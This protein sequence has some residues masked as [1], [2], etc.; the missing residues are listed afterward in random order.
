V[1][2]WELALPDQTDNS[3]KILTTD[4]T[5]ASWEAKVAEVSEAEAKAGTEAGLRQWSPVRVAQ[6]IAELAPKE[7]IREARTSNTILGVADSGK[8]IDVT[9]GTFTQTFTA[10]ATLGDGWYVWYKNSG[11]GVVTTDPNGA[12]T[13]D[14]VSTGTIESGD[15]FLITSDGTNLQC[16]KIYGRK[17]HYITATDATWTVPAG[18]NELFV[19][20]VGGG[21]GGGYARQNGYSGVSGAGGGYAEKTIPVDAGDTKNITIGAKGDGGTAADTTASTAGG[22]TSFDTDCSATGGG[23]GSD[24]FNYG[25]SHYTE[26]AGGSGSNGDLNIHGENSVA[27]RWD[28]SSTPYNVTSSG[29]S[30]FGPGIKQSM[31][32]TD[33]SDYGVGGTGAGESTGNN[34][35]GGDGYQGLCIIWY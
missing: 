32:A 26:I 6:A 34:I 4:G 22:T 18:I 29:G 33:A 7:V 14:G 23:A 2:S 3:G 20:I 10:A 25:I 16:T 1:I 15:T 13:I 27:E 21:G 30:F 28:I 12:E 11:T 8:L 5:D 19:Q 17:P 31:S 9:S 35:D 24:D